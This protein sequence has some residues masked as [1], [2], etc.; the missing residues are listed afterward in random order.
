MVETGNALLS[1]M[2]IVVCESS[3]VL[4]WDSLFWA[5]LHDGACKPTALLQEGKASLGD[6]RGGLLS[7]GWAP[8]SW[9]T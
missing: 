4:H 9:Q 6:W 3:P 5:G 1:G 7:P 2:V 8:W